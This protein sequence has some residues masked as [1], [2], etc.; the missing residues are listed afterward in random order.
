MLIY[1]RNCRTWGQTTNK[2]DTEQRRLFTPI[3]IFVIN[4]NLYRAIW[5]LRGVIYARNW[6]TCNRRRI[7]MARGNAASLY[8]PPQEK[9][10]ILVLIVSPMRKII[11][12]R[13]YGRNWR[14]RNRTMARIKDAFY[15]PRKYFGS[16]FRCLSR[17]VEL[18]GA[19]IYG[20]NWRNCG[21]T[22]S[23]DGA[24]QRSLF[25]SG[26]NKYHRFLI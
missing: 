25:T 12:V 21:Q 18:L 15:T 16:H 9:I 19:P 22:T 7:T 4:P 1:R 14:A 2:E 5:K 8:T 20:W 26:K 13:I 6:R 24:E 10:Y 11:R 3:D 17:F 23:N